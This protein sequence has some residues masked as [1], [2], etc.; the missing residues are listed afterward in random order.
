MSQKHRYKFVS[1]KKKV[2]K[3]LTGD[4]THEF[5]STCRSKPIH[6]TTCGRGGF[7]LLKKVLN[8]FHTSKWCSTCC[9]MSKLCFTWQYWTFVEPIKLW[10]LMVKR[11]LLIVNQ[12]TNKDPS[13]PP[14]RSGRLIHWPM[15]LG[16]PLNNRFSNW[17]CPTWLRNSWLQEP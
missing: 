3:A 9:H 14:N 13:L 15:G 11:W 7:I 6:T 8:C 12:P 1:E 10:P 4:R 5:E 2:T 16:N 17:V